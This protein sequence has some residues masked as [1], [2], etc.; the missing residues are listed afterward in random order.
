MNKVCNIIRKQLYFTDIGISL[1]F[2]L[3][4]NY[5]ARNLLGKLLVD[6]LKVAD[7]VHFTLY[8]SFKNTFFH[9]SSKSAF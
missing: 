3:Q 1:Y 5:F 2:F 6:I 4:G 8:K 9:D 7:L